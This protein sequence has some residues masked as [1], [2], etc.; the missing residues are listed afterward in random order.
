MQTT[1]DISPEVLAAA[2]RLAEARST[3]VDVVV[4]ELLRKG[5]AES[6]YVEMRDGLPTIIPLPGTPP[7]TSDDVARDLDED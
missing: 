4:T 3:T 6:P 1:L 7:I 5:L 2:R